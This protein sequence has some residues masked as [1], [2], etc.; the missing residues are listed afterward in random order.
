[1]RDIAGA[2]TAPF[3]VKS[4]FDDESSL[5]KEQVREDSYQISLNIHILKQYTC[6]AQCS[7]CTL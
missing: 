6:S 3:S 1:M 5:A 7:R 2:A 4:F